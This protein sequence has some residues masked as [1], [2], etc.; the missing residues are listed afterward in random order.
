MKIPTLLSFSRRRESRSNIVRSTL[1]LV[2][3][4]SGAGTVA[5]A[6]EANMRTSATLFPLAD[7]RL[8]ASPFLDAQNTNRHYLLALEPDKLLAPFQREAGVPVKQDSY[9]NWESSG[10]DGHMGGHYLSALALMAAS[11]GDAEVLARLNYFVAELKKCQDKN[12]NG[13]LGGIPGGSEAWQAIQAGK[14]QADNFSVNGK[15]VPW[16]NLHKIFAGL[17]D[18]YLYTGNQQAR[19]MLIAISDWAINL[20][21]KLTPEQMQTMLKSEHGGMNEVLADVAQITGEDKYLALARS[22][23]HQAILA[24]LLQGQDQ[25]TGLHA[26]TQIPK[27]IGFKRIGDITGQSDW[28]QAAQFFWQTVVDHRTVAIGGNS[29]KEHF[30]DDK[31]FSS[32]IN[33]VEG[34]ETCNTYNMLKLTELLFQSDAKVKYSDY[35]ERALYNHILSS[36]RPETGGFFYFTPMRPNHYRVYSQ[37][38]K[39]MWCCVGSGIESH[40]KY[41]EFIYAHQGDTLYV[42]LLI[43]STLNWREQGV[44]LTQSTRFPDAETSTI[45]IHTGKKFELKIRYPSW[46]AAGRLSIRLN[47]KSIKFSG[48]P[49]DYISLQRSWKIGDQI[50]IKLPMQTH[51]EQMPGK[52]NY[53][54]VLHGA[55]V[56]AAKTHVFANEKLNFIADDSRMGHI[57]QGPV[58]P[59][60]SAPMFVID[61]KNSKNIDHKF[62]PVAGQPLTFTAAGLIQGKDAKTLKLIPFYRLHDARYMLYWPTTNTAQFVTLQASMAKA[63]ATRLALDAQTIDQVAPGEQQ[64]ESDHFFKAEGAD[65]GINNGQRW[66]H[67][68]AWFS[69]ELSDRN[70]Q[71][72][73]LRLRFSRLDAGRTFDLLINDRLIQTIVLGKD[74][75]Q[76][77]YTQDYA[78]PSELVNTSGGKLIVKFVVH[79]GS[80]AGGVYGLRLLR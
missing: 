21:S 61:D 18:A 62:K 53:Y 7:V 72:K 73:T 25:L 41:G 27:V 34:P 75:A 77:L 16:Y 2:L 47:K 33:E 45:T 14:I 46:V 23:S 10:L 8:T 56:L 79:P 76:E 5:A 66:R 55:I 40:A 58:C 11:T 1:I 32:M 22:F 30:H 51:L 19:I 13:Y 64:P 60:E 63:E 49:G 6:E 36:Q 15:W 68:T 26:N 31:D 44:Q 17:R 29:V 78:L 57:A 38:D 37:V 24:P 35:Y 54:A 69:Y 48:A 9:G 52:S 80:V 50:E 39:A 4:L 65:T 43:P 70:L 12:G 71:A 67:A 74:M 28:Q 59:L 20:S 42:N 3:L